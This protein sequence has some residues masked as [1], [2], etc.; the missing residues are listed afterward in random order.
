MIFNYV[1]SQR[2][3]VQGSWKAVL[4]CYGKEWEIHPQGGGNGN[5][6]LTKP[7]D[8]LVDG[9]SF[10]DFV[11][12]YYGRVHLTEKLAERFQKDV[13]KGKLQLNK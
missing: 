12:D 5:W 3:V 10:R 2:M 1:E 9:K 7:A 11:L 6:L 13:E 4:K 8:I